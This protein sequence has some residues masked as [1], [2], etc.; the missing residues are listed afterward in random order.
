MNVVAL[1]LD[2]HRAFDLGGVPHAFGGALAFGYYAETRATNDADVSVFVDPDH[3][4]PVFDLLRPLGLEPVP[5]LEA[6]PLAGFELRRD[7]TG[8]RCDLFP[9]LDERYA[10][11]RERCVV[12]PFGPERVP[13]PFLAVQDVVMFKLSFGRGRDWVDL[14]SLVA[15]NPDLDVDQIAD[16]LVHLRGPSMHPR[17]A[18][19]RAM[20]RT[21]RDGRT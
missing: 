5:R 9:D 19:L 3:L 1:T 8:D 16:L 2:V 11:I 10:E 13:L 6:T 12:F 15:Y 14:E 7:A 20:V 18:R 21:T 4:D 17:L